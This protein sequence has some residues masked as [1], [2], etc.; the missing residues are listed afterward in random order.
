MVFFVC[1]SLGT[2]AGIRREEAAPKMGRDRACRK[3]GAGGA[4]ATAGGSDERFLLTKQQDRTKTSGGGMDAAC[5]CRA[6]GRGAYL[7]GENASPVTVT[8][9]GLARPPVAPG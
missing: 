6:G 2:G 7:A 3:P 5:Y 4:D 8:R 9:T 1:R